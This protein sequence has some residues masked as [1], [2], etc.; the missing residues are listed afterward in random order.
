MPEKAK[1]SI[2]GQTVS[3]EGPKGS[4]T[5]SFDKSVKI[6]LNDNV[7]QVAPVSDSRHSRAMFGT[8]RSI[9]NG[10][11]IGVVEGYTKK[12]EIKGVGFRAVLKGNVL[13]LALGYSHPCELEIPEGIKVTVAEN[14]KLTVEG[15][16]KQMVGQ[17]TAEIYAF[18]PAEPYKGKG[19][20]IEGKYV[21]RKEGKKSA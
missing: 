2:D 19:V 12:L 21:R 4:L 20:H 9:I 15:A 6:E 18:F 14:T 3:V 11:V 5:K 7:V 1:V 10:M 13:D 8:V 17:V 16:D